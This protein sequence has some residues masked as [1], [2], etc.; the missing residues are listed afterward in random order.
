MGG[1]RT[2]Y[3]WP[4]AYVYESWNE[5]PTESVAEL[6]AIH[7]QEEIDPSTREPVPRVENG[8]RLRGSLA[9]LHRR[10]LSPS[11]TNPGLRMSEN[12]R[13]DRADGHSS[14][15]MSMISPLV[16]TQSAAPGTG[17]VPNTVILRVRRDETCR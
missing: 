13:R 17:P 3:V 1:G 14:G 7:I 12:R 10:R 4:S 9:L 5:V 2:I 16:S 6:G 8:N 15:S 11:I